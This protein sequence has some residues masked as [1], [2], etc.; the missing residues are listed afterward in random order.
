VDAF[1]S[2]VGL[3]RK[4]V[5]QPAFRDLLDGELRPGPVILDDEQLEKWIR[6]N[7]GRSHHLAGSCKMGPKT[8]P[9]AVVGPDLKVY[10]LE[11]L[12]VADCSIMPTVTSGNTHAAAIVIGE[13]AAE[14]I[15][16]H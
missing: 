7:I 11:G 16:S 14:L 1:V 3:V 10:G 4:I 8:D 12:R 6:A 13:K 2:A 9:F 15:R 5:G